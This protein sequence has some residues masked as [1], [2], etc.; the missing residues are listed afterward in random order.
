MKNFIIDLVSGSW[1]NVLLF[2]MVWIRMGDV[3]EMLF[4]FYDI[5]SW[6]IYID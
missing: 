4:F 6:S 1:I 5:L 2:L 3:R